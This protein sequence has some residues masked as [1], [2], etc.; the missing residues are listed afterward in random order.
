MLLQLKIFA[1][2]HDALEGHR[3]HVGKPPTHFDLLL[4]PVP[5]AQ[6]QQ[7]H[8]QLY[9]SMRLHLLEL[10]LNLALLF[11]LDRRWVEASEVCLKAGHVEP[12]RKQLQYLLPLGVARA[13]ALY[14]WPARDA[15]D[16]ELPSH[17]WR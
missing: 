6:R 15:I 12:L 16:L 4:H 11:V 8:H 17:L 5:V 7:A 3:T 9:L 10:I 13:R 1:S 2:D 14:R